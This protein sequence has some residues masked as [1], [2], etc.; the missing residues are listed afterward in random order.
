MGGKGITLTDEMTEYLVAHSDPPRSDVHDRLI[1]ATAEA[2]GDLSIMQVAPEQGPWLT[3]MARLLGAGRAV[4]VGTFTGYSALCIA[5]GLGSAGRLSCFDISAEFVDVGR[6]FWA[7]AGVADR[8]DVTIGPAADGLAQLPA[9][10]QIDLAFIDADKTGYAD[11]YG[12]LLPRMRVGGLI[13]ADNTL[14]SGRVI[15]DTV[16]DPDTVAIRAYNDMVVADDRV[17]ALLVNIGDGLMLAR[18]R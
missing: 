1:A 6:P 2:M 3:F 16:D 15:D 9:D 17:D 11:Y 13:V 10:D 8:I 12:E 4:E 7:E 18:K 14:W 5:E